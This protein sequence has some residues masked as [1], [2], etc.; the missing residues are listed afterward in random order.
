VTGPFQ[1]GW[2]WASVDY[3]WAMVLDSL[4]TIQKNTT[5]VLLLLSSK[6]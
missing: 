5:N 4:I 6:V 2:D 1:P 3:R